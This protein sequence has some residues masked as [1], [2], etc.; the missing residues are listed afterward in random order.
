[1]KRTFEKGYL[2]GWTEEIFTIV[3]RITRNPPVYRIKDY[4]GEVL[5]GTFYEP[6]LQQVMKTDEIYKIENIIKE[7]KRQGKKEYLVKWVGYHKSMN[8][9]VSEDD[10]VPL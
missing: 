4:N 9:W 7:R 6:E 5:E 3:Q 10:L 8:S 1:M 2:P